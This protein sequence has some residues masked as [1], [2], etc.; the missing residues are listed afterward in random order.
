MLN[1]INKL[2]TS[3][4]RLII[5]VLAI[6]I[7]YLGYKV[8]SK[9]S[10]ETTMTDSVLLERKIKNVGKL[11]VTEGHFAE[12]ITYEDQEKFIGD[13]V[14]FDKKALIVANAEVTITYDLHLISYTIN[15]TAKT[16]TIK[17]I[18]KPEV[19]IYPTLEFYD[20]NQ[21]KFNPFDGEDYN[22]INKKV[23]A[24][25]QKKI[26]QSSIITNAEN[27]LVSELSKVLILTNSMGYTLVYKGKSLDE[28]TLS[29][30][31]D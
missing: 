15:E 30:S 28:K 10:N 23:K 8:I 14:T 4:E 2:F 22:K 17:N 16:V 27:R 21:S 29:S 24:D 11:V 18:P 31:F 9:K 1:I 20:V 25:F 26:N 7:L 19:K 13:W 6:V 3:I 12:V 5:V